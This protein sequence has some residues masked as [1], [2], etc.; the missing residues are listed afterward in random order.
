MPTGTTF[1][2]VR[3]GDYP[4]IGRV[5]AGRTRGHSLSAL[6][7]E[8]AERAAGVLAEGPIAAVAASP[9]ERARQTAAPI[10]ARCG[11]AVEVD[12]DLDE[13][14]FGDWTGM[15]FAALHARPDWLAFNIFRSTAPIPGGETMLDAQRRGL[16]AINRLRLRFPDRE[17][18]VVSHGDV[19]KAVV[20]HF[21]AVPLDLFARIEIAPGS[22]S[23]VVV[24]E[25]GARILGVNLPPGA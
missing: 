25:T 20:A 5:L 21:L 22:R 24:D 19:I 15:D 14:D 9:L 7:R 10:A 16:A 11:L 12:P 2:L 8:Q 3:H 13:I 1:H 17:V 23:I 18:A 6:G 4:L